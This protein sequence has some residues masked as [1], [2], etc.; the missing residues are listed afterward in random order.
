MSPARVGYY[1][2]IGASLIAVVFLS[3]AEGM[4]SR[5]IIEIE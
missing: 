1:L 3:A 5:Q 4:G 2:R